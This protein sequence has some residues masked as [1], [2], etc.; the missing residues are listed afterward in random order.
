MSDA[1]DNLPMIGIQHVT[2]ITVED[3]S[4]SNIEHEHAKIHESEHWFYKDVFDF[5]TTAGTIHNIVV[6]VG[7][8]EPHF[9]FECYGS[10]EM[11]IEIYEG[12][13]VTAATGTA[14]SILN[15]NRNSLVAPVTTFL[16]DATVTSNGTLIWKGKTGVSRAAGAA[17]GQVSEIILKKSTKYTMLFTKPASGV[18]WLAGSLSFYEE[19][20]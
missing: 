17:T 9:K 11:D 16:K 14:I 7:A 10:Q 3:G 15:N 12:S 6:A 18:A 19:D 4:I 13:T 20:E 1:L 5:V 8:A 2:G